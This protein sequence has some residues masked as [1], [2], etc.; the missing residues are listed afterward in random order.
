MSN[1]EMQNFEFSLL[2]VNLFLAHLFSFL[3]CIHSFLLEWKCLLC[4]I[5]YYKYI[6]YFKHFKIYPYYLII[7]KCAMYFVHIHHPLS[8]LFRYTLNHP[9]TLHSL[10]PLP[11][12]HKIHSVLPTFKWVWAIHWDI[13]G[14]SEAVTRK[15]TN[16]SSP[17][18]VSYQLVTA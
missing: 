18:V 15:K 12:T 10:F 1:T 16:S 5:E 13:T 8:P 17:V 3:P 2:G 11:P 14:L 9:P 4:A 7:L 6:I